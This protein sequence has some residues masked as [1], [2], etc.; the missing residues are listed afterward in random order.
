MIPKVECCTRALYGGVNTTHI[1]DG[2]VAHSILLE[3]FTDKGI[4]TMVVR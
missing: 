4:G 1:L 3:V 2:R